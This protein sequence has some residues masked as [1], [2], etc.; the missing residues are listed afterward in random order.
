MLQVE[1]LTKSFGD[2][3]LFS[4]I[5][6][7]IDRGQKVGLIAPNGSGKSTLLRILLGLEPQD[8]GSVTYERDLTKAF[9]PQLP[10]LPEEGTVLEACFSKYDPIAQLTLRWELAIA[11]DDSTAMEQLLPEMEASGAWSYEQRAKEILGALG[12]H[13]YARP[14]KGLSGGEKK[15]VALAGTLIS[16]PDLLFLDEPTN[17]LDLKS[18]EWLEGY[19]SRSTM[20]LLLITHDRYFLDRVC[21]HIIELDGGKLYRYKGNYDYYL[22]KREERHEEAEAARERALNLYRRELDWMRRQP[23]ARGTKAQYRIDAFHALE[24]KTKVT[25]STQQ[26]ELGGANIGHL[27]KKIFETEHV[28]KRYGEK[29][30]LNDFSYIFSRRDKVGIVGENGVGKT[31]FLRMLLGEVTPDSGRFDIGETIR[32]GYYSQ[33]APTFDPHKRVIDIV[34]DMAESFALPTG[35]NIERISASQLLTRFLFPPERQYTPIEKLSG[36][37]LRRL[38]LCTVLVTAPN[39]LILDEPTNDLDILTLQA[40]EEYLLEFSGCVLIVSHDRFFMDKV[41]QHLLCFE[42]EGKVRDFP[43]NYTLYRA[44][45]GAREEEEAKHKEK[46]NIIPSEPKRPS[47]T[48]TP[49]LTYAEKKELEGLEGRITTLEEEKLALEATLSAGTLTHAELITASERIGVLINELDELVLRQLELE[50]KTS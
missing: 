34:E 26:V 42:G 49:K 3:L 37:E 32:F 50:E 48:R 47:S 2:R 5:A 8:S 21:N 29:V 38:Y 46:K 33:Q 20:G 44:W 36:G 30:I 7:S 11:Q 22:E 17:H 23:Q 35:S 25:H 40:L 27:G 6:F 13:D 18:I 14:L 4:D 24:E 12:I 10:D 45:Q 28:C 15:R 1:Q 16:Q 43:G 31:T 19:L 9:L 39:F 41:V